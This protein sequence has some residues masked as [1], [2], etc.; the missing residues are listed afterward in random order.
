M[1]D[2]R[3]TVYGPVGLRSHQEPGEQGYFSEASELTEPICDLCPAKE[4]CL[5]G[6]N[7]MSEAEV[8]L[9]LV[10][11]GFVA[12]LISIARPLDMGR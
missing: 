10:I 2:V 1:K 11:V 7:G 3:E 5:Y 8:A 4:S 12:L 9:V 6:R